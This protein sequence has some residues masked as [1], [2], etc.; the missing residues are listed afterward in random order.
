M[1]TF[2]P[3]KL[4]DSKDEQKRG[5]VHNVNKAT[6]PVVLADG[7][8]AS[9]SSVQVTPVVA[10]STTKRTSQTNLRTLLLNGGY[11]LASSLANTM[12][13]LLLRFQSIAGAGNTKDIDAIPYQCMD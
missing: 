3:Q 7:T 12:T 9:Q 5:H 2:F 13:K 1:C 8:Y 11:F 6:G 10:E 4:A